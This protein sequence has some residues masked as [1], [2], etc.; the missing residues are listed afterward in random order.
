MR[1]LLRSFFTFFLLVLS[2]GLGD[3]EV[4]TAFFLS[5]SFVSV[6]QHSPLRSF[7]PFFFPRKYLFLRSFLDFFSFSISVWSRDLAAFR[8]R[9]SLLP[10]IQTFLSRSP[11][12]RSVVHSRFEEGL[13][14]FCIT[15]Q[16]FCVH[17]KRF[18][19]FHS[20]MH[21][22]SR[23]FAN[24]SVRPEGLDKTNFFVS[25]FASFLFSCHVVNFQI[26]NFSILNDIT[27]FLSDAI[28]KNHKS[29]SINPER[30]LKHH[31]S[32]MERHEN[33]ALG[34]PTPVTEPHETEAVTSKPISVTPTSLIKMEQ[35]PAQHGA[36][37]LNS[38]LDGSRSVSNTEKS[39]YKSDTEVLSI[40]PNSS[41]VVD[42][43]LG[44]K[45][46]VA[47]KT[48]KQAVATVSKKSPNCSFRAPAVHEAVHSREVTPQPSRSA[49][50]TSISSCQSLLKDQNFENQLP[51]CRSF[52]SSLC[53]DIPLSLSFS[54]VSHTSSVDSVL[55]ATQSL[56]QT[57]TP[58]QNHQ[59]SNASCSEKPQFIEFSLEERASSSLSLPA[60]FSPSLQFRDFP[61]GHSMPSTIT[62]GSCNSPFDANQQPVS[63]N[64]NPENKFGGSQPALRCPLITGR[65]RTLR[66]ST[67]TI[68]HSAEMH[69]AGNPIVPRTY[70]PAKNLHQTVE[71]ND[72]LASNHQ[73]KISDYI[74]SNQHLAGQLELLRGMNES[75]LAELIFLRQQHHNYTTA[76]QSTPSPTPGTAQDSK[77]NL[78]SHLKEEKQTLQDEVQK[79]KEELRQYRNLAAYSQNT[80]LHHSE[81]TAVCPSQDNVNIYH[82]EELVLRRRIADLQHQVSQLQ[83]SN[84]S[85]SAQLVGAKTRISQ[86]ETDNHKLTEHLQ[87]EENDVALKKSA[88][89]VSQ[90]SEEEDNVKNRT[91]IGDV[92]AQTDTDSRS[93]SVGGSLGKEKRKKT[94]DHSRRQ[95]SKEHETLN[96]TEREENIISTVSISQNS[97]PALKELHFENKVYPIPKKSEKSITE[98]KSVIEAQN[99]AT[100]K[101]TTSDNGAKLAKSTIIPSTTSDSTSLLLAAPSLPQV[102][103]T[104]QDFPSEDYSDT[105]TDVLL[106]AVALDRNKPSSPERK[107]EGWNHRRRMSIDS[108]GSST[109]THSDFEMSGSSSNLATMK[110]RSQSVEFRGQTLSDHSIEKPT[111]R[112][113]LK[114]VNGTRYMDSSSSAWDIDKAKK[115]PYVS[116]NKK[117]ISGSEASKSVVVLT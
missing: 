47:D 52:S 46:E 32:K 75:L 10:R 104:D 100:R 24:S 109:L 86:L 77:D 112:E 34:T 31:N 21:S 70:P 69:E 48:A 39:I 22:L 3:D 71:I 105:G 23:I 12:L 33:R 95:S 103:S 60:R 89:K 5:L 79:L 20:K 13:F 116:S 83:E 57:G 110:K 49:D 99:D 28:D 44:S 17:S 37:R 58:L 106:R 18:H 113:A 61:A 68:S 82:S 88:K 38:S 84:L 108:V 4:E 64:H 107:D 50:S 9:R 102:Y 15:N 19:V 91:H 35:S 59:T 62:G 16:N 87:N 92:H 53:Q 66:H 115:M 25:L 43:V 111:T 101:Q 114:T 72:V 41:C 2:R 54:S 1:L 63:E 81:T 42:D 26:R 14:F 40:V 94:S 74:D 85:L 65:S 98:T 80:P 67:P 76:S 117:I 11:R 73:P 36:P 7:L 55:L 27:F 8:V 56:D 90:P 30:S 29:E 6:C 93:E 78:V 45:L 97:Q 96:K 51:F